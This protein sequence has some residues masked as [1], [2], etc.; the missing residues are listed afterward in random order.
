MFILPTQRLILRHFHILDCQSMVRVLGDPEVM[1]FSSGVKTI[2]ETRAWIQACLEQYYQTW[3]FGPYAVVEQR[4]HQ[5]IGYCGLSFS[6]DVG[7]Q[8]EVSL[9]YRLARPAWGQGYA[10][11]AA[12]SV[13]DFAFATLGI[14]RLIAT[15]D[16]S[17]TASIHVAKKIGMH[18]EKEIMLEGYDHP[19]DLYTITFE[20]GDH[21]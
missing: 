16:P 4:S 19:D 15:I 3:G 10:T 18:F 7:G 5:V 1:R 9:G 11:E 12:R 8:P 20:E 6:P 21:G 2:E 14:R 13:R 17:N